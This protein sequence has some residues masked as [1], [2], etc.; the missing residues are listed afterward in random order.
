MGSAGFRAQRRNGNSGFPGPTP[1]WEQ[2]VF[3]PNAT[4][5]CMSDGP[6]V[7]T[8]RMHGLNLAF[9][10]LT[11]HQPTLGVFR[12]TRPRWG[13][14]PDQSPD[15]GC[16]RRP[17]VECGC[18]GPARRL[19]RGSMRANGGRSVKPGPW[20]RRGRCVTSIG[21][22]HSLSTPQAL[23]KCSPSTPQ[24]LGNLLVGVQESRRL[25]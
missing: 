15:T 6:H 23:P 2:R 19:G 13:T 7:M 22:K 1:P 17:D 18:L 14:W 11:D 24:A 9:T 20:R 4:M 3:G 25:C 8:V 12:P 10:D 16:S 21:P 5:G